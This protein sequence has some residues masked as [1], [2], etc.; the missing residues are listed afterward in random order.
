M[1]WH[2]NARVTQGVPGTNAPSYP[3]GAEASSY[4]LR[5]LSAICSGIVQAQFYTVG[6][7]K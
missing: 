6:S 5:V 1:C 4:G 7:L 2:T 3:G